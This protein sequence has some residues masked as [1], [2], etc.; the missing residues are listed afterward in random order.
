MATTPFGTT[1]DVSSEVI[2]P[3][4]LLDRSVRYNMPDYQRRQA[5]G[6]G[7]MNQWL[8]EV[9]ALDDD[10]VKP[11]GEI[12]TLPNGSFNAGAV[13]V[14][15]VSDGQQRT[16]G[17]GETIAVAR[18]KLREEYGERKMAKSLDQKYLRIRTSTGTEPAISLTELDDTAFQALLNDTTASVGHTGLEALVQ[19]IHNWMDDNLATV[20][21][22]KTFVRK[23]LDQQVITHTQL[24][25]GHSGYEEF[26]THNSQRSNLTPVDRIKTL[27]MA[28]AANS[29]GVTKS[30]VDTAWYRARDALDEENVSEERFWRY[31]TMANSL[32]PVTD[33]VTKGTL[34]SEVEEIV[35]ERI[36][37]SGT[38]LERFTIET[39]D[40]S[41]LHRDIATETVSAFSPSVNKIVNYHLCR[42]DT[43]G[44]NPARLLVLRAL[45][46]GISGADLVELL[47]RLEKFTFPR[48]VTDKR[49][50][51]EVRAFITIA[52]TGFKSGTSLFDVVDDEFEGLM[53]STVEF[54]QEFAQ[55]DW[56]AGKSTKYVLSTLEGEY[57][58]P[59]GPPFGGHYPELEVE[60]V[61][62]RKAFTT[63]KY[64]PWKKVLDV[65]EEEFEL[66]KQDIGN[67]TLFEERLNRKAGSAPYDEK[68]SLYRDS[69]ARM[70]QEVA[71]RDDWSADVIE[72]RSRMLADIA[73][74]VWEV[75]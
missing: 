41:E 52:H 68:R 65:S 24:G 6:Q 32:F 26:A 17:T 5:W 60:H 35:T 72:E 14:Y 9:W 54:A 63:K 56:R 53:P 23:F 22:L 73:A 28:T 33:K 45:R 75:N 21:D 39:A 27:V 61:A 58:S 18:D 47:E 31:W 13:A 8:T 11:L 42:L 46:E 10:E 7:L 37:G 25:P 2:T 70:T 1:H 3:H 51:D 74:Q 59:S 29:A 50:P 71:G 48:R 43:V 62:P 57:F 69:E 40:A 34:F 30:N 38:G 16:L 55:A 66:V 20:D 44:A 49:V 15:N 67:T 19:A 36:P 64:A 4:Q 12:T